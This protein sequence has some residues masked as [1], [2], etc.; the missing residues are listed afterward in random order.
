MSAKK[1]L[2]VVLYWHMHQPEYRDVSS[3][4]YRLPWTYLH[5]LKDY[6]DM[7]SH[8][9]ANPQARAIVNFAPV[10]L[11]QIED[12][13]NQV[14]HCLKDN[15]TIRDPHLAALIASSLPTDGESRIGL[16]KDCLRAQEQRMIA[17]FPAY[18]R[19]AEIARWLQ[20]HH[21]ALVY[22]DHQYLV[23]LMVWHHLVWMGETVRRTDDRIK[24]LIEKGS[25]YTLAERWILLEVI[26]ELLGS[27]IER[28]RRLAERGQIELSVTPYAH[29]IVPLLLDVQSA[30]EAM[31]EADLPEQGNYPGGLERTRWQF[32]R[33]LKTFKRFFGFR[34]EGCW[35]SEG[36][37]S[38]ATLSLLDEFGFRWTA[39]GEN[40]LRNSLTA[41]GRE[42]DEDSC[43]HGVYRMGQNAVNCFFRD[44]GLSDLIGFT[45]S[46]WHADDAVAN[47]V[48]HLENIAATCRTHP[49]AVVS[50]IL[51]GENAW[52]HYPENG[53]YFLEALYRELSDHS[54]LELTTYSRLLDTHPKVEKLS[55]LA[56]GSWVYGTFSTWVGEKDKNRGWDMLIEAKRCF[57]KVMQSGRLNTEQR[58]Q[59]EL[60]LA[61]CEGSDWFWWFGDYNSVEA[62]SDFESLFRHNLVHLYRI[63]GETPP[64]YLHEVFTHGKG[65]PAMGGTM[66]PGQELS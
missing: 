8:L 10:L 32:E 13:A 1:P 38:E 40:V 6:V 25:R 19:L 54:E 35:P 61:I 31:P 4:E 51:D 34:P 5:A 43:L 56:A 15:T 58:E 46:H 48:H 16:I 17:R 39:S 27:V 59:A 52:E 33:G 29:P 3:G 23:D 53:Y 22:I 60:Q 18:R 62:V 64:D 41:A 65:A 66:R 57:D 2:K 45:Y 37:L 21:E 20:D 14:K 55:R 42:P 49:G 24:Q 11:E 50:I 30:R 63:L 47:F 12:Y 44:D 28:Y 7:A 9:E 36:S 26:G